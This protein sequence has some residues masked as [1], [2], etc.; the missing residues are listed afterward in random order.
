MEQ[1]RREKL[2]QIDQLKD[3]FLANTSHELRTPLNG[4]IGIAE[5]LEDK[6]ENN[7]QVENL[8]M[9]ISSARRLS[10]LVD[11]LLD[12][13]RIRNQEV[14]LNQK[15]IDPYALVE[16]M[17][18]LNQALAQKK[19]LSLSHSVAK[20]L[21]PIHGDENRL[22]QILQNLIGN[23]IKFTPKG[24]IEVSAKEHEGKMLLSV[25]DSGIGIN[26]EK[27][28]SIFL[29]FSQA[30]A[31]ISRTYSGSGLGLSISKKLI[32]LHGG[33]LWV[34]SVPGEGSIFTFSIPLSWEQV[35]EKELQAPLVSHLVEVSKTDSARPKG[36]S[37]PKKALSKG[38]KSFK[39]LIVDDEPINQ[40]VF[41]N[42]F[43]DQAVETYSAMNGE[44]AI[45]LLEQE[46]KFDLVLLDV[47]MPRMTGYDV[48]KHIRQKYSASEL[49]V[50][51]VTAKN[52]VQDL[53]EG[54]AT[55]AND[56]LAKP[57]SKDELL[58]R[59]NT[60]LNLYSINSATGKFVP[61]QFLRALGKNNITEVQLGDYVAK[62][63]NVF[64][65]D[66]RRYTSLSEQMSPEE[67]FRFVN[68][69]A[70]RMGPI[71]QKHQGFVNQ[72]MG[73]G[74]MAIFQDKVENALQAA[75]D[76]Q[77][78]IRIYNHERTAMSRPAIEVGM[79]I[80]TG[81]LVMGI[82]G[83]QKRSEPATIADTV[84]LASRM[85][86]L[87]KVYGAKLLISEDSFQALSSPENFPHRFLG[88]VQVK[89]K[90]QAIGVYEC[91]DL[92]DNSADLPKWKNRAKFQEALTSYY[93]GEFKKARNF[94]EDLHW[95]DKEDRAV[96]YYLK[97]A[98]HYLQNGAPEA[99]A[100]VEMMQSK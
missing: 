79:G 13:S 62:N 22:Q 85:E 97:N 3:Q 78:T 18:K 41:Q 64:F 88:K 23:A 49:P 56:Y 67:T 61:T 81:P 80:H 30:D 46:G 12:F 37:G 40:Q 6:A 50:I 53:V 71:I 96:A 47:M 27:Q 38:Q 16:M 39:I 1:E 31:S 5:A 19:K 48:C 9:I 73:D 75:L 100:G 83:D 59:V 36:N 32:E 60:H 11:D 66:I 8:N 70:G 58:A 82:I 86:G 51:M 45:D 29:E 63:V 99:W 72:Y 15:A 34:Q 26:K 24:F 35:E 4:I 65:S 76:M 77:R 93:Q 55:G 14:R 68:N 20:D 52:Q 7:F 95:E 21:P 69:Y 92:E 91:F 42:H 33:E 25:T 10:S 54:L 89:G 28:Q 43:L 84:N 98:Q 90:A 87:T 74:I 94:F 17:V 44:E 57:F 2:E